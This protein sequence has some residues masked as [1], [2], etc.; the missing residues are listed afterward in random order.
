[1]H[2][3]VFKGSNPKVWYWHF[4]NKGRVTANNEAFPSKSNA[5]RAAKGVVKAVMKKGCY[6]CTPLFVSTEKPD[7]L[8]I[9]WG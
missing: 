8:E 7:C 2:I 3:E 5:I 4:K 9:R 6:V 1:M